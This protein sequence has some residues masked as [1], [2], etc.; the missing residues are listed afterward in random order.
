MNE[1]RALS[2]CCRQCDWEY[3]H[4]RLSLLVQVLGT[5]CDDSPELEIAVD[6]VL[7]YRTKSSTDANGGEKL[8]W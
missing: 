5:S 7:S 8:M 4:Y 2:R 3:M 6:V 1:V